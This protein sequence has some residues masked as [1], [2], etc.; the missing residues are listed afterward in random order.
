MGNW[1][2]DYGFRKNTGG[3]LTEEEIIDN[4]YNMLMD[5]GSRMLHAIQDFFNINFHSKEE[6]VDFYRKNC[7]VKNFSNSEKV[8]T[9]LCA[10]GSGRVIKEWT[11]KQK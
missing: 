11:D 10:L 2:K 6:A 7:Y 3:V 8:F 1:K 9:S 4:V 5:S